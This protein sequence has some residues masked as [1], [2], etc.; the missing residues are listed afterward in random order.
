MPNDVTVEGFKELE[1]ALLSI[2]DGEKADAIQRTALR[3]V[4]EVIQPALVTATP[5][6]VE[7][8]GKDSLAPGAL[9]AA[10]RSSIRVPKDGSAA[11]ATVGFGGLDYV[12]RFVEYGHVNPTA[13]RG[14]KH[15]PAHP[16]VRPTE[17]ATHEAALEA[18]TETLEAEIEAVLAGK[19]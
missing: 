17:D 5:V 10:V 3:A 19:K 14:L 6:R 2:S 9:K 4:V 1:E 13:N 7:K 8:G 16:F 18:Y 15:T 11:T 12:A